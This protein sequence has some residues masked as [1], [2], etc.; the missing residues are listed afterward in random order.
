MAPSSDSSRR[1][2][3][4]H[5]ALGGMASLSIPGIITEALAGEKQAPVTLKKDSVL[6]FQGDSIT[7]AGRN[8]E[9]QEVNSSRNLGGGYA[10]L[11]AAE[12]LHAH[13]QKNLKIYNK[14]ISGFKVYQVA[15]RWE[16][17]TLA[18][19]PDVLSI[20]IGVNDFWHTL[21]SGYKGTLQ[22]YQ[23]DFKALLDR[24]KQRLPDVQLIVGEPF[25]VKDIK[26]VD[27]KW[28][29]AF[30]AYRHAA[31]DLARQFNAAFVPYQSVYEKAQKQA[32][33]VYW[34]YDGVHPTLAGAQLM[35][36]A[37]LKAV[38]P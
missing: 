7:D 16:T 12:L 38:K 33:G 37:W 23:Q 13:P 28:F 18:L 26:A 2:F 29:P 32:P 30:D 15:E 10:M 1:R 14:G 27:E 8:R 11:A 20:L 3:L 21:S 25:A 9:A 35:A 36:Q 24:T 34:T 4:K 5:T 17:D 22:T 31:R 19:K 6:L